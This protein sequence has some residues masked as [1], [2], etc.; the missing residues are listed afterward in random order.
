MKRLAILVSISLVIGIPL[1]YGYENL[2][3][4]KIQEVCTTESNQLSESN[5]SN[6]VEEF[7]KVGEEL[8]QERLESD[9]ELSVV[10][11]CVGVNDEVSKGMIVDC[12]VDV[13]GYDRELV[14]EVIDRMDWNWE[15]N[16]KKTFRSLLN[17]GS[18]PDRIPLMLRALQFTEEEIQYA[19]DNH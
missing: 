8:E 18:D 6:W 19:I 17:E 11:I 15:Y 2:N 12:L 5:Q 1:L 9:I 10:R 4:I 16:C 7:N 14:S 3:S 13:H